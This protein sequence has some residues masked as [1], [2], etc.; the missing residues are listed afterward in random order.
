MHDGR[1]PNRSVSAAATIERQ[2]PRRIAVIR[3]AGLFALW[4]VLMHS[5]KAADLAIGLGATVAATW[6]SLR[7]LPPATGSVRFGS[8]LMLLPHLFWESVRAGVDVA[9]RALA[10]RPVL[11][12]GFVSCP[13]SFP[14][15][16]ARN[17]FA[18][19]TS[20]LPGTVACGEVNGVLVYHC[21]DVTQP[22]A[23]QLWEEERRLSRALLAGE[24]YG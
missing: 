7:L 8:L 17:T 3:G 21:L 9:R 19:I 6:V 5:V 24:S 22:V 2:S 1:E 14:P 20:L 18:T 16:M 4:L 13:L 12:P 11:N 10:P 15:G 23:E